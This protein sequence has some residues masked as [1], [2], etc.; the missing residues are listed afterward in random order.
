MSTSRELSKSHIAEFL[1]QKAARAVAIGAGRASARLLELLDSDSEHVS[2][3]AAK[4]TLAVAGIKPSSEASVNLNLEI[5]AGYILDLRE[6]EQTY[7]K[8]CR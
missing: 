1:R 2:F 4:H 6:P 5:K 8:I 7:R 3:D